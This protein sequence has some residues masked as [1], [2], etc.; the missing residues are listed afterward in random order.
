MVGRTIWG[1]GAVFV[2]VGA[3]LFLPSGSPAGAQSQVNASTR[4]PH[5]PLNIPCQNCHTVSGWKPI[6]NIPEFDHNQTRYPLRGMH[7]AVACT[8]CHIKP[9]FTNVGQKC[10][11]CHADIHK[12][13]FGANCEQCHT[14]KGWQVS[15]EQIKRHTNRFP[16]LGAHAAVDCEACHKNGALSN[17]STMSTQCYSCHA[18]DY[19]ATTG[20]SHVSAGFSTTCEQCHR[21]DNW[22]GVNFDHLKYTGFA[23]TGMHATLDCT[24]CH[25]GGKFKGTPSNCVGCHLPDF[26]GTTNPNH[27]SLNLPQTC[28]TCHTTNA[29]QPATFDHSLVGFPLTGAHATLQ[30][31]QCHLNGNFNLTSTD[32]ASCHMKDYKGTTNPNHTQAG[33]PTTCATCHN[34]TSWANASFNHANTGFPLTGAHATT[35]C[36]QC[37]INGNY[38]LTNATCVSC[39]MKDYQGTTDP[40]HVQAGI[41]QTCEVCH[42]TVNWG[43]ANF[44]H[45]STGFPL[46]GAHTNLP[47]SQCHVNGNYKL[48]SGAC[49][50][51]H[52]KDYNG[53]TDPNHAQAGFPTTCDTCHST[54]SWSGAQFDHSKTGWPLTG[55]HQPLQCSLCHVNNNYKLSN[56]ACVTCHLN[57]YNNTNN[58]PHQ[59][60]GFPQQCEL[61]H[62]TVLW[63]DGKFDHGSTGWPLTGAHTKVICNQCHVNN[64]YKNT[65][66]DCYSC[67]KKDYDGTTNPNHKAAGFPTTCQTCHDTTTWLDAKFNHTWFPMNHGNANGCSSCHTNP[68][69]Y[70]VFSCTICHAK[71][72][73][74]QHHQG[75][76]NYVY[77][78]TNCYQCHPSGGGG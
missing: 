22:F 1:T 2:L 23:L 3:L 64:N 49:S 71:G 70:A 27:V 20:P 6:R 61:C 58:P 51:C 12:R 65:P 59:A 62:D 76:R 43:N 16:L 39:H 74:D 13:Q 68:S 56:T 19:Q 24:A 78:S 14:V 28:Q 10:A 29:W 26:R 9:V 15:V 21:F 63:A 44:N 31:S 36:T 5:G 40:N 77:N 33:I 32:C 11:D 66:T 7:Q 73:T 60:A 34:T 18:K 72:P 48:T 50:T 4:S 17:F 55:A 42:S 30:C 69:N 35:P 54:S 52:M 45:A 25:I 46:T 57:D 53:T 75:V 47:C 37:H 41:P 38:N 8:Q 67:H